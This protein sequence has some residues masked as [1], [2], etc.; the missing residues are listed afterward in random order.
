[1]DAY[2]LAFEPGWRRHVDAMDGPTRER[3]WKKIQQLKQPMKHRHM[4]HGLPYF[5][6][7]AGGFRIVLEVA[8]AEKKKTIIFV[9]EHKQYEAW[10]KSQ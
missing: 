8:E 9:G 2:E 4:R 7:E 6:E 3:I 10:Y 1:M 5:V